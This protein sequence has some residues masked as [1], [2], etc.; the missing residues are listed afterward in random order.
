MVTV[1]LHTNTVSYCMQN[2]KP[3]R[4]APRG[5]PDASQTIALDNDLV[6]I[7]A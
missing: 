1:L 2:Y 5:T 4:L 6:Q 3:N 7:V